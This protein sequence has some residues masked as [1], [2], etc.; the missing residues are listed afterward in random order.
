VIFASKTPRD[1]NHDREP[2]ESDGLR[3]TRERYLGMDPAHRKAAWLYNPRPEFDHV[4]H[5]PPNPILVWLRK[6]S[7]PGMQ[8]VA[9]RFV[10]EHWLGTVTILPALGIADFTEEHAAHALPIIARLAKG[11]PA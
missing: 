7:R 8:A 1:L 4:Q 2:Y 6:V 9:A 10:L 3:I 5:N 11:A